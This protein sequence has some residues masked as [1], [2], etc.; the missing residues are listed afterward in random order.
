MQNTKE[1]QKVET[2]IQQTFT[3]PVSAKQAFT[4]FT[5][6][7]SKWWP[8]EYTWSQDVLETI[9]IE[10]QVNGRCFERGPHSFECDWGRVLVWEP[11]HQ[12]QFTWQISPR[13]E[14]VP[15]P[16]QA[17]KITV[18][19]EEMAEDATTKITVTHSHF[20][21]HG[22]GWQDYRSALADQYGWPYILDCYIK[23][24]S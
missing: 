6:E 15:N 3:V 5:A 24:I 21:R 14:P 1:Q 19:F 8:A 2:E 10:P 23:Y 16:A 18:R 7:L 9:G 20:D 11:P 12:L 17:S 4:S 22:E 13:R